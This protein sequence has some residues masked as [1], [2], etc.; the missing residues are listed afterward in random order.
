[1]NKTLGQVFSSAWATTTK[2]FLPLFVGQLIYAGIFFGAAL[3][4]ILPV[5]QNPY[6]PFVFVLTIMGI[7]LIFVCAIFLTPLYAGFMAAIIHQ[8]NVTGVATSFKTAWEHAKRNYTKFLTTFLVTLLFTFIF[9]FVLGIIS[10][11]IMIPAAFSAAFSASYS[12]FSALTMMLSMLIPVAIVAGVLGL[13]FGVGVI[14]A[15]YIPEV[16]GKSAFKAFFA[17][18]RYAYNGK[19]WRNLGH[20]L[21]IA[22]IIGAIT[23]TVSAIMNN[24]GNVNFSYPMNSSYMGSFAYSQPFSMLGAGS[25]AVISLVTALISIIVSSVVGT[26]HQSFLYEI[27]KNA[28]F[29]SDV[30]DAVKRLQAPQGRLNY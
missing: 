13:L 10:M 6:S 14:G 4:C 22:L 27:Y 21:L 17:S 9:A 15:R 2:N 24:V 11:L 18:F 20:F 12:S 8:Y 28:R 19:F 23:G 1:M 30:K 29:S 5:A 16:E 3:L 25:A 7:I 26:F